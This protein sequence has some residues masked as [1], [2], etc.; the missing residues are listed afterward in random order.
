MIGIKPDVR[1]LVA[2]LKN[3]HFESKRFSIASRLGEIDDEEKVYLLIE[4]LEDKNPRVREAAV[5]ALGG[6]MR[7]AHARALGPLLAALNKETD[8]EVKKWMVRKLAS[9]ASVSEKTD[10]DRAVDVL[11]GILKTDQGSLRGIAAESLGWIKD[12]KAIEPLLEVLDV[13]PFYALNALIEITG[14]RNQEVWKKWSKE[15][16]L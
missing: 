16:K 11:I 5:V 7:K 13:E 3:D 9:V 6:R 14:E 15:K 8:L 10:K 4:L 1:D 12:K 2:S